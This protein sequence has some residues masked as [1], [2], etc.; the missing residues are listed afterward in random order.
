M[1][2]SKQNSINPEDK[3]LRDKLFQLNPAQHREILHILALGDADV[4]F[5]DPNR[6][7]IEPLQP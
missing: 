3:A 4:V 7:W 1:N 2:S 5:M 6:Q